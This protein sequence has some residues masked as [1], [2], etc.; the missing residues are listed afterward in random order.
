MKF[1]LIDGIK[2]EANKGATGLCQFCSSD[3]IA[4]CGDIKI[5][6]WAHKSK[7][8]CDIWRE[9]ETEWHRHMER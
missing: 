4:K 3:L 8:N 5:H 7:R 9:N 1:A 2:K 6:H